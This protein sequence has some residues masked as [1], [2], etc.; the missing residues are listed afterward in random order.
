MVV[1]IL[2]IVITLGGGD[3]G[4][5]LELA[6]LEH[7]YLYL[8][9]QC[10]YIL[11]QLLDQ[12]LL[13]LYSLHVSLQ[14]LV[15]PRLLIQHVLLLPDQLVTLLLPKVHIALK[16]SILTLMIVDQLLNLKLMPL[17][18]LL[19]QLLRVTHIRRDLIN[20]DFRLCPRLI[21]S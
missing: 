1:F 5:Y 8:V 9:R 3:R 21:V 14:L 19:Q 17:S 18:L 7:Q 2:K 12:V 11:C 4:R 13:L 10:L 6:L 15:Q 16:A 20:L